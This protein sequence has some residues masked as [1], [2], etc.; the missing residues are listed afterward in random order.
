MPRDDTV[1]IILAAGQGTRMKSDLAKVLHRIEGRP[2]IHYVV[3]CAIRAG[4]RRIV[5]VVG[6][7]K[8][9]VVEAL[10]DYPVQFAVQAEQNGTGHAVQTALAVVPEREGSVVVLVGDAPFLRASTL[11]AFVEEHVSSG[12]DCTVLTAAVPDPHGYGRIVR[13]PA[14]NMTAIVEHDDCTETERRIREVNSAMY[15]FKLPSL[16][17]CA[18]LLT[19]DNVQGELYLTDVVSIMRSKGMKLGTFTAPDWREMLGINTVE[20]LGQGGAILD[21]LREEA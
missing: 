2:I 12:S 1:C 20:Q 5:V 16:I 18:R 8:E 21:A 10:R 17:S 9:K 4:L 11:R 13:D 6:F 14:G 15:C 7:Q 19:D 3:D